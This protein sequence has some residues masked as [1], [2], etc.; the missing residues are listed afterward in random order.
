MITVTADEW[1]HL[2]VMITAGY[3]NVLKQTELL[4]AMPTNDGITIYSPS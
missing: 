1:A 3:D 2:G 4:S